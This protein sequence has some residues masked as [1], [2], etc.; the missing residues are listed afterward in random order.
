[1]RDIYDNAVDS[2]K[3]GMQHFLGEAGFSSRKHAILT[4][5]HCIE[6]LLKEYL[7]RINP[8]LTYRNID[9]KISEDSPT[10]GVSELLMRLEN[11]QLS[12]PE[13]EVSIIQKMQRKRNRIEHHRYVEEID[14]KKTIAESLKFILF[15]AEHVLGERLEN[16]IDA[17]LLRNIQNLVLEYN[18]L[19]SLADYRLE[20]WMKET[21]PDWNAEETD[22]PED[23]EGTLDCP[24]CRQS[25][26][27][28]TDVEVPQCFWCNTK[29]SAAEC[30]DCGMT[31]RKDDE[32]HCY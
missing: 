2:L 22:S 15:F 5:F 12:L 10:A 20:K 16:D 31:Y 9:K 19:R 4:L 6:L 25:Y 26:L 7:Y 24:E 23:F 29:V 28:I 3:V 17:P 1:M 30:E 32:H 11:L 13:E 14:D 8:I 21:W 27:V 18:E